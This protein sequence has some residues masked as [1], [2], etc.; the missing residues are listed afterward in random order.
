MTGY[1]GGTGFDD[2]GRLRRMVA[3]LTAATY[4]DGDLAAAIQRYPVIDAQGYYP[5]ESAWTETFDL[6]LAAA[7]VWGE[8]AANVAA[9]FAFDADGASFQKQQQYEHY[10]AQARQ[11]RSRRVAG[12]WEAETVRQTSTPSWIG[13]VNDPYE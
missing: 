1:V 3:E 11:W 9:N 12:A 4:S 8:K 2:I 10:V 7:E 5:P 6:A 13:N